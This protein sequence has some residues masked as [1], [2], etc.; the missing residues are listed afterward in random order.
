MTTVFPCPPY[1]RTHRAGQAIYEVT[2]NA[3]LNSYNVDTKIQHA[4]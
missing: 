1:M 2:Q 3:K 4:R